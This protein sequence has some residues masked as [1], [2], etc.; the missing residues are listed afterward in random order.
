MLLIINYALLLRFRAEVSPVMRALA[1]VFVSCAS[2]VI[3]SAVGVSVI[4]FNTS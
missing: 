1:N 3:E 2:A 4:L